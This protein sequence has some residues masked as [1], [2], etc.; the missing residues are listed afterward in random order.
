MILE[1]KD[2][3][4]GFWNIHNRK[5]E[6]LY[7]DDEKIHTVNSL[8]LGFIN[9]HNKTK[10]LKVWYSKLEKLDN[11]EYIWISHKINQVKFESICRM[12]NLKGICINWSSIKNLDCLENLTNL[13]HLNLGLSSGIESIKPVGEIQNLIT[14]ESENLKKVK[15]WN[16]L[17]NLTQL[18]GLGIYGGMYKRL[19]LESIDFVKELLNLKYLFLIS[20]SLLNKS[21]KPIENLKE[22]RSLK[23]TNDWPEEEFQKLRTELPKLEYGNVANDKQTQYL[24]RILGKK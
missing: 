20:T 22:L 1:E 11:I 2:I 10:E 6:Y 7:C 9:E 21:L 17:S 23:L 3:E 16:Y 13:Q 24:K 14:F 5:P 19:K 18:E 15:D 12:K 8:G 4:N